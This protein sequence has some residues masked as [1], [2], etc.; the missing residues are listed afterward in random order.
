MKLIYS[1]SEH[2]Y[3]PDELARAYP[4]LV[5]RELSTPL[6]KLQPES[7]SQSTGP[8]DCDARAARLATSVISTHTRL[9]LLVSHWLISV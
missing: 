7:A 6:I 9:R 4:R 1:M 5:Q 2:A 8:H 3:L